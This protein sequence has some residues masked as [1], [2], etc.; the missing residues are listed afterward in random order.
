MTFLPRD[1]G[2]FL[3]KRKTIELHF[4]LFTARPMTVSFALSSETNPV[5]F[6]VIIY[7]RNPYEKPSSKLHCRILRCAVPVVFVYIKKG[8]KLS[9]SKHNCLYFVFF[10]IRLMTCFSPCAGPSSGHKIY[11]EENYIV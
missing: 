6:V 3:N 8:R 10:I 2:S 11:K 7:N 4:T 9:K 5:G 1:L